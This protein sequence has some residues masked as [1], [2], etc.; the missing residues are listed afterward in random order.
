MVCKENYTDVSCFLEPPSLIKKNSSG[1]KIRDDVAVC[2]SD[3][4]LRLLLTSSGTHLK[5]PVSNLPGIHLLDRMT[6]LLRIYLLVT[7]HF[8]YTVFQEKL[9][10]I[11]KRAQ[12]IQS[13]PS[14]RALSWAPQHPSAGKANTG[15]SATPP[16]RHFFFFF[17][18]LPF[19]CLS[20]SGDKAATLIY[21]P[22]SNFP[23]AT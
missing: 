2:K 21:G 4:L 22:S 17:F 3:R 15:L 7:V 16:D 10:F 20:A 19:E 18:L 8:F 1:S 23:G 6:Q 14:L 11:P 13:W 5:I 9:F 12:M